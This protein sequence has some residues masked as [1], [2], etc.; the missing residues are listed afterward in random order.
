MTFCGTIDYMAPEMLKNEVHDYSLDIW[1]L[2]IL[3]FEL[4]HGY[5]P[6]KGKQWRIFFIFLGRNDSEKCS[7]IIKNVP[8]QFEPFV[9]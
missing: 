8:I 6:F 3:L 1:C 4:I 7:N 5:A 9:S 2:G